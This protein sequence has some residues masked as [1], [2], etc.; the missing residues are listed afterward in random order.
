MGQRFENAAVQ[1]PCGKCRICLKKRQRDWIFRMQKELQRSTSSCFLTL[2][3][4]QAPLSE[5]GLMTL[6]SQDLTKFFKRLRLKSPNKLKY[7]AVGEYGSKYSRPHYH[8][9]VF[10][11][12]QHLIARSDRIES[13]WHGGSWNGAL[14][15]IIQVDA[16]TAGSIGYV[17]GYCNQGTWTPEHDRDT[18]L[19]DD[20]RPHYSAMSK[21]LGWNYLTPNMV[22]YHVQNKIG[23]VT[24]PGGGIQRL[25]RYFRDKIFSKLEREEMA[26][27]AAE[28]EA[29]DLD[30]WFQS[31][32]HQVEY[33]KM[34]QKKFEQ[35]LKLE[36]QAL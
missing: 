29:F 5:N 8:A 3:Y 13:I 32:D 11:L 10:N 4:E 31:V 9:I 16:C 28:L 25:P 21:G 24:T 2:T 30:K 36:R 26:R 15:G 12:P 33:I 35:K 20:R 1:V 7:Y 14:P 22:K 19:I 27:E 17:A 6:R 18:G 34:E 23:Y